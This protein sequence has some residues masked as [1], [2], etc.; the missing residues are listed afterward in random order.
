MSENQHSFIRLIAA[1]IFGAAVVYLLNTKGCIGDEYSAKNDT[2]FIT[3]VQKIRDTIERVI[4]NSK[5]KY[6]TKVDS[7]F[8]EVPQNVDTNAILKRYFANY[9]YNDSIKDT[10]IAG[11][12]TQKISK[13]KI[14]EQKFKYRLLQPQ[15]IITNTTVVTPQA[16]PKRIIYVGLDVGGNKQLFQAQVQGYLKDKKDWIYGGGYGVTD[17]TIH[18]KFGLPI[19]LRK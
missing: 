13:N 19:K 7:F 17:K 14:I 5:F 16:Q 2:T 18:V 15:T 8:V 1:C 10:V 6:F 3:K 11:L 4:D 12:L 9:T